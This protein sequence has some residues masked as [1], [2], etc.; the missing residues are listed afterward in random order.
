MLQGKDLILAIDIPN[1]GTRA[2][3]AAKSCD[4]ELNTD[5]IGICA[6]HG[7]GGWK[8][9]KP[10]TLSW[11][12]SSSC[13]VADQ[14]DVETLMDLQ[15]AKTPLLLRFYDTELKTYRKGYAYIASI[16]ES[17]SKGDLVSLSI[18]FTPAGALE[19]VE[20]TNI[21]LLPPSAQVADR[22]VECRKQSGVYVPY[23][24]DIGGAITF[25]KMFTIARMAKIRLHTPGGNKA[26]I[27][28]VEAGLGVS[29]ITTAITAK[30]NAWL[31]SKTILH[32][33]DIRGLGEDAEIV[34]PAGTYGLVYDNED[35]SVT[36]ITAKYLV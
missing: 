21:P 13:L 16:K 6:P 7:S 20:W 26:C 5:F 12:V 18:S 35:S 4:F 23:I 9:N 22:Y 30:N 24:E 3:A 36:S 27:I 25:V 33:H 2:I 11:S 32:A 29:E 17:G 19:K 15:I 14:A 34:V 10:T 1:G 28:L 31:R 8:H